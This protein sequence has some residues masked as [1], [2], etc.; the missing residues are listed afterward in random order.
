MNKVLC[1]FI[2]G[3]RNKF[4]N[5][6]K[7]DLGMFL[8]SAGTPDSTIDTLAALDIMI[9]SHSIAYHKDAMSKN[10]LETVE[11]NLATSTNNALILNIDDYYSIHT[12]RM[13][14]S[15]TTSTAEHLATIL[16]NP[17]KNRPPIPRQNIHNPVLVDASLI[18]TEIDNHFMSAYSLSYN[19][20][21]GFCFVTDKKKLEELTVHSHDTSL[22]SI[23][24]YIKAIHVAISTPTINRHIEEGNEESAN[25]D[26]SIPIPAIKM[27]EAWL[28]HLPLEYSSSNKPR[29]SG[30]DFSNCA[31]TNKISEE[32]GRVLPC[33]NVVEID[34][35]TS[36]DD[37]DNTKKS[38]DGIS[39][40]WDDIIWWFLLL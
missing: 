39:A 35:T 12:K 17:I 3:I 26:S 20:Y 38:A 34:E 21:W 7:R 6:T 27:E 23:E 32:T 8:D 30:C 28:C 22:H 18:K 4:V 1:Y 37:D 33:G 11:S 9:T 13:P 24:D 40:P 2:C 19:Q 25:A 10:H 36:K 29:L 31:I 15:T 14:N 5:N 16:L